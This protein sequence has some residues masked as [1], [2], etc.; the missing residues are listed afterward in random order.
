MVAKQARGTGPSYPAAPAA[1]HLPTAATG[2]S[3]RR[4]LRFPPTVVAP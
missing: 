3:D 4:T 1:G 2:R